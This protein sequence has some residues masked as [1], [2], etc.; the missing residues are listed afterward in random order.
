MALGGALAPAAG[1]QCEANLAEERMRAVKPVLDR[2]R[3]Q[4]K[5]LRDFEISDSVEPKMGPLAE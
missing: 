3:A 5:A 2:R 1:A 4:L